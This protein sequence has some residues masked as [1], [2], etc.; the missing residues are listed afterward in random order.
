MKSPVSEYGP[1]SKK[2]DRQIYCLT[3]SPDCK[4]WLIWT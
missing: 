1:D 2:L 4:V 3:I